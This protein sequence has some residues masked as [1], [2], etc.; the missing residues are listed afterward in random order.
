[1]Q[2]TKL[3][4][5]ARSSGVSRSSAT[6]SLIP[7]LP[8]GLST[9]AISVSTAALSVERLMTQFEITTSTES[10]GNGICSIIPLRKCTLVDAG[11]ARVALREGEHLVGHVDAVRDAGRA[12]ALCG[13]DHVDPA[14]GAEVE[15]GLA[16]VQ[17]GDRGRVA[18]AERGEGC[19]LRQLPALLGVVESFTEQGR[20]GLALATAAAAAA[21]AF[22][23]SITAR[24]DSA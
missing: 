20:L 9:R 18:A 7:I 8:P 1:M 24:A 14:A 12:D 6:T 10:A 19:G 21:A 5:S 17:V 11:V 3:P 23:P 16:L 2:P 4:R 13:Q 15:H 22:G